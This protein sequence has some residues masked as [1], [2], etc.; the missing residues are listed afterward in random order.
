VPLLLVL[1]ICFP[2]IYGFAQRLMTQN[3]R[4][5]A[6]VLNDVYDTFLGHS[7]LTG[8]FVCSA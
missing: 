2:S 6:F 4:Q 5:L 3:V 1:G 7:V 8:E